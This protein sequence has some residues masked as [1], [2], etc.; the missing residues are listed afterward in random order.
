MLSYHNFGLIKNADNIE[1]YFPKQ[2]SL[3]THDLDEKYLKAVENR[4]DIHD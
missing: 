2:L 4:F 1:G 3:N